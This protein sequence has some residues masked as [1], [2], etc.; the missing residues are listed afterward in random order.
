M[1]RSPVKTT[2][3]ALTLEYDGSNFNGW[4]VQ[5]GAPSVQEALERVLSKIADQPV[6]VVCAGRTDTGVH[7]T[8]QVVHF[9]SSSERSTR[10]WFLGS[11]TLLPRGV[12][13]LVVQPVP[14]D[15][16][17]RFS[18]IGR[19]YRYVIFN[20]PARPTYLRGRVTWVYRS[21]D[22]EKMKLAA[23]YLLGRH[24]FNA[25]RAMSCQSKQSVRELRQLNV[26]ARGQ[27]LWI[28]AE[29]DGFLK[30]M[31]RNIIGV[32]LAVGAG[33]QEPWWSREVLE[34]GKRQ[35]GGVTARPDGLYFSG[36]FYSDHYGLLMPPKC[37]FW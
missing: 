28:D 30:H 16:H 5:K 18:A 8:G 9:E 20:R 36:A 4:Q 13:V 17:A 15:F 25:Y 32:L 11:N 10:A 1:V 14:G 23:G 37:R 3:Y 2:R 22:V 31:V 27:W 24:D 19:S 29:A 34:S 35:R 21:L 6:R 33:E 7:A 12:A 26:Q